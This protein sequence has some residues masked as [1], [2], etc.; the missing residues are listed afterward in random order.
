MITVEFLGKLADLAG[1]P[2]TQ[3]AAPAHPLTH[4]QLIAAA[5]ANN[6][7]LAA[8]LADPRTRIARNG[9]LV[10]P[11]HLSAH[12]GDMIA[13]LPPVSGG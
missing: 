5:S 3:I 8:A 9:E 13:F 2:S 1:T 10:T 7:A 4:A 6:P 11:E 12:D